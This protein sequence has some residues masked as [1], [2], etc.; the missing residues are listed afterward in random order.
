MQDSNLLTNSFVFSLIFTFSIV[1][2]SFSIFPSPSV[3]TGET[4]AL[5]ETPAYLCVST[6]VCVCVCVCVLVLKH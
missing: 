4:V 5:E 6:D 3:W 2:L 1:S